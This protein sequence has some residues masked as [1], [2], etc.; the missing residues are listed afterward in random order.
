MGNLSIKRRQLYLALLF[1]APAFVLYTWVS[2][3]PLLEG[4]IISFYKWNGL[5]SDKSFVGLANYRKLIDD[6]RIWTVLS[7]DLILSVCRI[8]AILLL[9]FFFAEVISRIK[10]REREF[11]KI[12]FFFPNVLSIVII[13]TIWVFIYNPNFGLI[14]PLLDSVGL[15]S[16]TRAWLSDFE[17]ALFSLVPPMIWADVGFYMIIFIAAIKGVPSSLYESAMIDGASYMRQL[18]RITIPIVFD[19]VKIVLLLLVIGS[20]GSNFTFVNVMT[21]GGP[22]DSTQTIQFLLFQSAFTYNDFGYASTLG[23]FMT[24][25]ALVMSLVVNRLFKRDVIEY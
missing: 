22:G 14:N 16:W 13:S 10:L 17:T 12:I 7:H 2:L 19:H 20:F 11:Y 5:L 25:L 15:H 23:V 18:T 3:Y 9:S 21:G 8:V 1:I 6:S 4:L 24:T